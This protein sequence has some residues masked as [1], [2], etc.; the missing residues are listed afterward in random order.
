MK[1]VMKTTLAP[2][3]ISSPV[4]LTKR[5]NAPLSVR[6]RAEGETPSTPETSTPDVTPD[7]TIRKRSV[8]KVGGESTDGMA[9]F[10]TRRFGLAGGLAWVGASNRLIFF[11]F[12]LTFE[13]NLEYVP[14]Y[15]V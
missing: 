8:R 6:V 15:K 14:S 3:A 9:T 5:F 7:P 1:P 2:C 4:I 11:F 12:L 13:I 10:L